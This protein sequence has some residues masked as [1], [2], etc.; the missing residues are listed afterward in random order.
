M[1]TLQFINQKL[2]EA[3]SKKRNSEANI[4]LLIIL[5]IF[6]VSL[7]ILTIFNSALYLTE[8]TAFIAMATLASFVGW[9]L[10]FFIY[11]RTKSLQSYSFISEQIESLTR[12]YQDSLNAV[13]NI[14]D[15]KKLNLS[16]I[17][18]ALISNTS[19][20]LKLHYNPEILR[21]KTYAKWFAILFSTFFIAGVVISQDNVILKK[22]L[23]GFRDWSSDM[24]T[25]FQ[26][27]PGNFRTRLGSTIKISAQLTR[28]A[29]VG[30]TV[31]VTILKSN[32][33]PEKIFMRHMGKNFYEASI[34]DIQENLNYFV[35]NANSISVTYSI[36]TFETPNIKEKEITIEPPFYTG[37]PLQK[38]SEFEY[39]TA[40]ENSRI[41]IKM[42]SNKPVDAFFKNKSN[43]IPFT[44]DSNLSFIYLFRI[45]EYTEYTILLKDDEKHEYETNP[46]WV[47]ETIPDL[48]PSAEIKEPANDKKVLGVEDLEFKY[49][50]SDDYGLTKAQLVFQTPQEGLISIPLIIKKTEKG[51]SVIFDDN[52]SFNLLNLNIQN[53]D[54]ISYYIKLWDNKEPEPQVNVSAVKF[55]SVV[56]GKTEK[57]EKPPEEGQKGQTFRIDDLI[58]ESKRIYRGTIPLQF[59]KNATTVLEQSIVTANALGDLKTATV[60][61]LGK[62]SGILN[63]QVPP[64]IIQ[65]FDIASD[66]LDDAE[67]A[68][69]I[70]SIGTS[71]Q[72]QMIALQ[73]LYNL[74]KILEQDPSQSDEPS[75]ESAPT[76]SDK[77]KTDKKNQNAKNEEL[78]KK[79]QDWLNKLDELKEKNSGINHQLGKTS[80][81]LTEDEKEYFSDK[82]KQIKGQIQ[83]LADEMQ[84]NIE[85]FPV[86]DHLN[87]AKREATNEEYN[88][89]KGLKQ[90]AL[91]HA[92]KT[93][94]FLNQAMQQLKSIKK[95]MDQSALQQAQK[96]ASDIMNKQTDIKN[97]TQKENDSKEQEKL[98]KDQEDLKSDLKNLQEQIK[99]AIQQTEVSSPQAANELEKGLSDLI[100]E[101]LDQKMGK[102]SKSIFYGLKDKALQEQNGILKGLQA[103]K[104]QIQKAS[105]QMSDVDKQQLLKALAQL[106]QIKESPKESSEKQKA[107]DIKSAID[108]MGGTNTPQFLKDTVKLA[109]Q[110]KDSPTGKEAG[111]T[112]DQLLM[113]AMNLIEKKLK[114]MEM[115][116]QVRKKMNQQMPPD[117]YKKMVEEYFQNL[118]RKNQ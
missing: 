40:P 105:E 39:I 11:L 96:S 91:K 3:Y 100:K 99:D 68:M 19:S 23:W 20:Q 94:F 4:F 43:L 14:I 74:A 73:S 59:E 38:L 33:P 102:S 61:R 89:A 57:E 88:L 69:R 60:L 84:S 58:A 62:L 6:S 77:K 75:E 56:P 5:N 34:Y 81:N 101:N 79:I 98:S 44:R 106:G 37:L 42:V 82:K 17:E 24:N 72:S 21:P 95:E 45:K 104:E 109:E 13:A 25:Y 49:T 12:E 112:A 113:E 28:E 35:S 53:G 29:N 71:L 110:I 48:P 111:I 92:V 66:S 117:V 1:E 30:A 47:I 41:Q 16:I 115:K 67:K 54:I 86:A 15:Q 116:D 32:L 76:D 87:S 27:E 65:L 97:K 80:N 108:E 55:L 10:L 107:E 64:E 9:G 52:I 114:S 46:E 8:F 7:L 51:K 36:S 103:T 93:D 70:N 90:N 78:K 63:G 50:L 31:F 2:K 85:V 18:S 22:S 118:N 26:I 83:N